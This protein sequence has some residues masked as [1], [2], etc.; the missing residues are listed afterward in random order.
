MLVLSSEKIRD[1]ALMPRLIECLQK[2]FRTECLVP[3]RQV[4]K[5]PGGAGER[6]FISMPAFDVEGGAAVK[7]AAV[8]PDNQAKGRFGTAIEDQHLI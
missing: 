2:A 1:L 6:L 4:A 7:L 5:M 8:F 3:P